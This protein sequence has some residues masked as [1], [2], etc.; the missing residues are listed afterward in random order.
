MLV[1]QSDLVDAVQI[2]TWNVRPL[3]TPTQVIRGREKLTGIVVV[4]GLGGVA[5]HRAGRHRHRGHP[6][7]RLLRHAAI[8]SHR[9][10]VHDGVLR[11]V[12]QDGPPAVRHLGQ[13]LHVGSGVFDGSERFGRFA[14]PG[15]ECRLGECVSV[16]FALR[17]DPQFN[18][19]NQQVSDTLFVILFATGAG[20]LTV[21]QGGTT[22][23][24]PV[25]AGPNKLNHTLVATAS[26]TAVLRD[27]DAREVFT[28]T[29]PLV[30]GQDTPSGYN[31]NAITA[32][33]PW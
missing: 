33:G 20:Q 13:D 8:R 26:V 29:A 19:P 9:L 32:S 21:A 30:Y 4:L 28:F 16:F 25:V 12:V 14:G 6:S 7:R 23:T 15:G 3:T 5:L 10:P 1:A 31:F 11:V 24:A 2:V 27:A 22:W 17:R 18:E